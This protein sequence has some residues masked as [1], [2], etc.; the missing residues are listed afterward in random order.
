MS[1]LLLEVVEMLGQ[2]MAK[3]APIT[4]RAGCGVLSALRFLGLQS[5]DT[6]VAQAR[7]RD[8]YLLLVLRSPTIMAGTNRPFRPGS[9]DN[10]PIRFGICKHNGFIGSLFVVRS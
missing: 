8:R 4:I 10:W 5:R 2:T 1:S 6:L 3:V 7:T 9:Q